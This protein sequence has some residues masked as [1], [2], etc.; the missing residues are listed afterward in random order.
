MNDMPWITSYPD[1]V[2][3]DAEIAADAGAE[4]PGRHGREMAGPAGARVHG[5]ASS[6]I[7]S[8]A[9]LADRAAKGFQQLGVGPGVHVGLFLPNTPHYVDRVLRRAEG[10]RHGRQLFAARR[11][12]RCSSTRSRTARPTCW[13]RS[14]SRRCIR[15]W[16]RLL[17]ST[18][19]Q[20]ADRRQ[21]GRDDAGRR[22]RSRAQM[23]AASSW[24]RCRRTSATCA[25]PSCSTTTA[26]YEHARRSAIRARRSPCC[27]TP[28]ARPACPRARC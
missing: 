23:K 9:T 5:P 22:T 6:A 7:A 13:S 28:A 20:E 2:R 19:L 10:R 12:R 17:G 8:S 21:P 16:R 15:R 4:D 24:S 27:S 1:G 18:R 11:R 25:S 26:R 3:W 14:T